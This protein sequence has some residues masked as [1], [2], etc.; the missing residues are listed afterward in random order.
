MP[1]VRFGPW[2]LDGIYPKKCKACSHPT[3]RDSIWCRE[4]QVEVSYV[5]NRLTDEQRA[6]GYM[7][8]EE[9]I[10]WYWVDPETGEPV[11]D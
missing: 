4:H 6:Q 7:Y 8:P 11:D 2:A 5:R 3:T 1:A 10:G 9:F